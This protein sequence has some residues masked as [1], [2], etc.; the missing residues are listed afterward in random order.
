MADPNPVLLVHLQ[1]D[2]DVHGD[3]IGRRWLSI[4]KEESI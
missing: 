2:T 1:E 3:D 4:N